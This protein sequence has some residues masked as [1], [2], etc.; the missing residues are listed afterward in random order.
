MTTSRPARIRIPLLLAVTTL[1][2]SIGAATVRTREGKVLEGD[3]RFNEAGALV[4][5]PGEGEPITIELKD[6]ARATFE[7]GTFFSSGSLLP[8][9]WAAQDIG[10]ARGSVRLDT[11]TLALRVEGRSTNL[12]SC[13]FVSRPMPSDGDFWVRVEG[14]TGNGPAN[15]GIM[16]RSENNSAF[17]AISLGNDGK[18]LFLSRGDPA[19]KEIRMTR[20]PSISTPMHLRL[21]KRD[22]T[23]TA[24]YAKDTRMWQTLAIEPVKISPQKTWREGEG[25]LQLLRASCGVFASSRGINT[26]A[27]ARLTPITMMLQ[28]LLGEYFADQDFVNLRMARLDPQV[29]FNWRTT[30]PSPV[31]DR[32]NFSVR[33]TGKVVARKAGNYRFCFDADDR[34]K[35]WINDT[36]M[37]SASLKKYGNELEIPYFP[38]HAGSSINVK[39]EY[40]NGG[41]EAS[42][43]LGWALQG[44]PPEVID[45]TNFLYMFNATNSPESIALSRVTNNTPAVGGVLLRDGS[46][47]AGA[48]RSADESAVRISYPGKKDV[49][50]LNS[51][52]ARIHLRPS[53]SPLRFEIAQGRT[54]VFTKSGDFLES[55]FKRIE[56]DTLHMGSVLFGSK[57]FGIENGDAV[58]VVLNDFVPAR[59]GFEVT[60][61]DG[62]ALQ[63]PKITANAETITIHEPILGTLSIP[64]TELFEIRAIG[65]ASGA[66]TDLH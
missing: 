36:E 39:L 24:M 7:S 20:G 5:R 38:L 62:S 65:L 63:V 2:F 9:G 33:W 44:H 56:G 23:V 22:T 27:T 66:N 19:R 21:Q 30:S 53:R 14:V 11:N 61:L 34:A 47:L 17:A 10:D 37:P 6:V 60:L 35:L 8:N 4:L 28:G 15:A 55:E 46:F 43:Q 3:L 45:M 57:K 31:L 49:T 54:G 42:V 40:E 29:R 41:G 52:V 25:D 59:S 50:V 16:I 64:A 12:T 48:V 26:L 18:L 1:V 58:A 13:H 51:R 32:N